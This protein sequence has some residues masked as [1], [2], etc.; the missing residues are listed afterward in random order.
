[1]SEGI[2]LKKVNLGGMYS[3]ERFVARFFEQT[4]SKAAQFSVGSGIH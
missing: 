1:L 3:G 4:A 2:E